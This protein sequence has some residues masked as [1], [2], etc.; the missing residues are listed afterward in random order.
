MNHNLESQPFMKP[1]LSS[2]RPPLAVLSNNSIEEDVTQENTEI[3]GDV[4]EGEIKE[5][6]VKEEKKEEKEE[7]PKEK[8]K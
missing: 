2:R 3:E 5:G 8:T 4:T 6:E 1:F 7:E